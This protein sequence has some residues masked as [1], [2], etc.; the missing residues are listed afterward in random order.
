MSAKPER[1]GVGERHCV[2]VSVYIYRNAVPYPRPCCPLLH[3]SLK[4]PPRLPSRR[5]H[6]CAPSPLAGCVCPQAPPHPAS[7]KSTA[8]WGSRWW[9]ACRPLSQPTRCGC[10]AALPRP[11]LPSPA[12]RLLCHTFFAYSHIYS[13]CE[14][15]V[16]SRRVEC[17]MPRGCFL[18]LVV[19]CSGCVCLC[20]NAG[21]NVALAVRVMVCA[22]AV[23]TRVWLIVSVFVGVCGV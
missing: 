7:N 14:G 10:T 3:F 18:A 12:V 22:G 20:S 15:A 17:L 5:L 8:Q 13:L 11:P 16:A 21:A 2:C 23:D 1:K 19:C 4:S 6:C 9:K